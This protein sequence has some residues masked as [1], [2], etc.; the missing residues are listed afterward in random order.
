MATSHFKGPLA[1]T[2]RG[3]VSQASNINTAVTL[4]KPSGTITTQAADAVAGAEDA[5]TFNNSVIE[6]EDVVVVVVAAYAGGGLPLATVTAVA[7]GSCT[8][9][10]T[11]I[12]PTTALDSTM[13]INFIVFKTNTDLD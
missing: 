4:N 5:F 11:N 2:D 7:D 1:V 8:I 9:N 13:T 12:H 3:T 6:A 10:I